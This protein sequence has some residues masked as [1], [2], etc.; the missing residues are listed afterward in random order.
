M[1]VGEERGA[2]LTQRASLYVS[3]AGRTVGN[4]QSKY[5]VG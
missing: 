4:A 1:S 2:S 3:T 5:T